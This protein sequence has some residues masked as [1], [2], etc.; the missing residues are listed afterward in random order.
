[1]TDSPV[2]SNGRDASVDQ[3]VT[4][5]IDAVAL[6]AGRN[7]MSPGETAP[8]PAPGATPL[9]TA[10]RSALGDQYEEMKRHAVIDQAGGRRLRL[11]KK[12]VL[13]VARIFTHHQNA[14]NRATIQSLQDMAAVVIVEQDERATLTEEIRRLQADVSSLVTAIH[15]QRAE[16]DN[17]LT[18]T[19][20]GIA[21]TQS[22]LSEQAAAL[23]RLGKEL[24]ELR[25]AHFDLARERVRDASAI[26]MQQGRLEM[27]L[28]EVRRHL[29]DDGPPREFLAAF[30]RELTDQL[31]SLYADFEGTFRGSREEIAARQTV[32]LDYVYSLKAG[33]APVLDL[34]CGRGEWV[35]LLTQHGIPAYGVDT[36]KPFVERNVE[37][38]LDV[39]L[40]DGAE[41]LGKV[42]EGSLGAITAFHLVEHIDLLALVELVDSSLRALAPGGALILETPNPTNVVVGSAAFYLDPTH[43]KPLHPQFLSFLVQSRGFVDVELRYLNP[44]PEPAFVVPPM[45]D[46]QQTAA[47]TRIV[48]YLNWAFFGPQDYAVIGRKAG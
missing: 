42:A 41:H 1:M 6:R 46:E 32:Y 34:G 27:L 16:I 28:R 23:D 26:T 4:R 22:G 40:E 36:N 12:L 10:G 38:G 31:A 25:V 45:P 2:V 48:D 3:T 29:P 33:T 47:M 24:F 7:T 11:L 37:R 15:T 21:S 20:A 44:S 19:Y 35:E 9:S 18:G 5:Y 43:L 14:F 39:R 8:G 30:S 13:R 17:R